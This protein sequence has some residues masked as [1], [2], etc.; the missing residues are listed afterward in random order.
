MGRSQAVHTPSLWPWSPNPSVNTL[1]LTAILKKWQYIS[2]QW[3]CKCCNIAWHISIPNEIFKKWQYI[4]NQWFKCNI[5]WRVSIQ[6]CCSPVWRRSTCGIV[7]SWGPTHPSCCSA[8][9]SF[10]PPSS[11]ASPPWRTTAAWLS[12]T[13]P[14]SPTHHPAARSPTCASGSPA[15]RRILQVSEGGEEN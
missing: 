12:P 13:S 2:N 7:S 5:A 9:C 8:H 3:C 10:S 4:S 14:A 1:H 15:W 11:S 6:S